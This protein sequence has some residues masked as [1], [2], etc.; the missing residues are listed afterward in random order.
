M[1]GARNLQSQRCGHAQRKAELLH[2]AEGLQLDLRET[3][4]LLDIPFSI[5]VHVMSARVLIFESRSPHL[6]ITV[7]DAFSQQSLPVGESQRRVIMYVLQTVAHILSF[8]ALPR[9]K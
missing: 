8:C 3:V 2:G 7:K 1:C 5:A 9:Q 4:V 6:V